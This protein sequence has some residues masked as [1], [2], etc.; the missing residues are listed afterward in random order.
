[1][2]KEL[3]AE[4]HITRTDEQCVTNPA[5]LLSAPGCKLQLFPRDFPQCLGSALQQSLGVVVALSRL[6]C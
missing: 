6:R 3:L 2:A 4:N 5:L 1:M